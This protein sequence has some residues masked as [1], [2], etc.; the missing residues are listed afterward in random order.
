MIVFGRRERTARI[1]RRED[2]AP[3]AELDGHAV[4]VEAT[5]TTVVPPGATVAVDALGTLVMSVAA[6]ED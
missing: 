3:G 1:L 5:A 6:E 4:I 2:L